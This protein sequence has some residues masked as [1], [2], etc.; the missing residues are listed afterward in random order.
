M[1][2]WCKCFRHDLWCLWL[3]HEKIT[4]QI[5]WKWSKI[6]CFFEKFPVFSVTK[7]KKCIDYV[8]CWFCACL[9]TPG[10]V[11]K[12]IDI[13]WLIFIVIPGQSLW[14]FIFSSLYIPILKWKFVKSA[15]Y[16][17]VHKY[18]LAQQN[19]F[20]FSIMKSWIFVV[21]ENVNS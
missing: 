4:V 12:W 16:S 15:P 1:L 3:I 10:R 18:F 19:F 21:S 9:T 2:L 17:N 8:K 11:V 7:P 5:W 20:I 14:P 6:V 13:N